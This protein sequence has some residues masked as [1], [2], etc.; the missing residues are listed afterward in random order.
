[1]GNERIPLADLPINTCVE[2]G[3]GSVAVIR[4]DDGKVVAFENRCPHANEQL[5]GSFVGDGIVRC[6]H[7]FWAFRTEDGSKVGVGQ[8]LTTVAVTIA[9]DWAEIA[10]P[11]PAA[12]RSF[13]EMMLDHA[14]T[15]SRDAP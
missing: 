6:P 11:K 14:R 12:K 1:M 13:R 4:C 7:H 9:G 5:T 2:A 15:W 10:V 8:G 3:D